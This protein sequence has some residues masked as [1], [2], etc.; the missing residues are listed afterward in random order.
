MKES[1]IWQKHEL[2]GQKA[3][4][5]STIYEWWL[6]R[7]QMLW[8][9]HNHLSLYLYQ[10]QSWLNMYHKN[11]TTAINCPSWVLFCISEW[12]FATHHQTWYAAPPSWD[13]LHT[14]FHSVPPQ[15]F[16]HPEKSAEGADFLLELI[17]PI[18]QLLNDPSPDK[19]EKIIQFLDKMTRK[20]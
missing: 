1:Y 8:W 19:A 20:F 10:S 11:Q 13:G 4:P 17:Q 2:G 3:A 5:V 9:R 7:H 18:N 12:Y 6:W 14:L 16:S 15:D